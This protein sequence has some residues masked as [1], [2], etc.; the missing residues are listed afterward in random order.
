VGGASTDNGAPAL[1]WGR[2]A[3]PDHEWQLIPDGDGHYRIA[4]YRS[5]LVLGVTGMSTASGAR[6]VQWAD[7]SV[8][9]A[10]AASGARQPGMLGSAVDLCGDSEWVDL[11]SGAVS[12]LDGDF[13]ISAWVDPARNSTW[14]RLFDLGTGTGAYMFLTLND[15]NALRFAITTGGAGG[16]Q[17]IDGTGTLPLNT[18]S[19]VTV[20]LSGTTGTLYVNGKAVGTNS[21]ITLHPAD[22]GATTRNWIGRSQ[23]NDPYL[24]AEVDDF[25]IYSRALDA[26]EVAD[27]AAGRAAAG[28]VVHYAFDEDGGATATDSS[29][30]GRDGTIESHPQSGNA[31]D[32]ATRDHLWTLTA[33]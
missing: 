1:V 22:L 30:S 10:C 3:T 11:P 25:S 31:D 7:G 17:R 32:S 21:A 6:V 23:Y 24:D 28:D 14:S 18:W 19:L 5:G 26:A 4:N 20:T 9:S 27:L 12:G 33:R 16:E 13:T 2:E 15:G 29:G 8:T